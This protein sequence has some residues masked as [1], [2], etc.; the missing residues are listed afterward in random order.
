M[1]CG[2]FLW[3]ISGAKKTGRS[4]SASSVLD[5]TDLESHLTLDINPVS[6]FMHS[7]VSS[8]S[9]CP[10]ALASELVEIMTGLLIW[11]DMCSDEPVE[12][13]ER[14]EPISGA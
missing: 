12:L 11:S 13:L 8:A 6:K 7:E 9:A 5:D 1:A 10:Y 14:F 2:L 3:E 4:A